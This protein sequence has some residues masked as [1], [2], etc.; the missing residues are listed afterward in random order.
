[1]HIEDQPSRERERERDAVRT[2]RIKMLLNQFCLSVR[3]K[4]GG[5]SREN[6]ANFSPRNMPPIQFPHKTVVYVQQIYRKYTIAKH[7]EPITI[8]DE[9]RKTIKFLRTLLPKP[10]IFATPLCYHSTNCVLLQANTQHC[11]TGHPKPKILRD[12]KNHTL[13]LSCQLS[14]QRRY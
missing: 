14:T 2:K 12:C 6:N 7:I 9:L 13:Y 4:K 11:L 10:C 3:K 1:M 5:R 8:F